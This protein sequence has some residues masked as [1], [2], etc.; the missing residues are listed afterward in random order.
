MHP[1]YTE[2]IGHSIKAK[3]FSYSPYSKFSVGAA[4]LTKSDKIFTGT[5]V[6]CASYSLCICAERVAF[7]KAISEGEKKFRAIAISSDHNE[8]IFP[9]GACR[10]FMSEF[11]DDIDVIVIKSKKDFIIKKLSVL[12]PDVFNKK[13]LL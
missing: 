1:K 2:L 7:S 5:N 12:I 11:S 4:L 9:C 13:I 8:Y 6:E 3:K 10:Q